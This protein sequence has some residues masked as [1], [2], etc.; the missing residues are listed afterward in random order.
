MCLCCLQD[1]RALGS[2]GR[3]ADEPWHRYAAQTQPPQ[4]QDA[5]RDGAQPIQILTG[6]PQCTRA[7]GVRHEWDI[8]HRRQGTCENGMS[9]VLQGTQKREQLL[10]AG[11]WDTTDNLTQG[12]EQGTGRQAKLW[13]FQG[14]G[15]EEQQ[16]KENTSGKRRTVFAKPGGERA[17]EDIWGICVL[18][19][20]EC[21][22]GVTHERSTKL[23][24]KGAWRTKMRAQS[25]CWEAPGWLS[26]L[27][28]ELLGLLISAQLMVSRLMGSSSMSGSA[29]NVEPA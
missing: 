23:G 17:C 7:S 5:E 24:W 14:K 2:S 3:K 6:Q 29:L 26:R 18:C 15:K 11:Q 22:A 12:M 28:S 21:M 1:E 10:G 19:S 20:L 13:R 16:V 8:W 9:Q 27:G 4:L 25:H